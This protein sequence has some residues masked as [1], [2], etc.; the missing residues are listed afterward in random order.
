MNLLVTQSDTN[1]KKGKNKIKINNL[2]DLS[3]L[4]PIQIISL[5]RKQLK[6]S[7]LP[8]SFLNIYF[9]LI[10]D[11][12]SFQYSRSCSMLKIAILYLC[13]DL[14][15]SLIF[16]AL[17]W[18]HHFLNKLVLLQ[19]PPAT[20]KRSNYSIKPIYL[21]GPPTSAEPYGNSTV[22]RPGLPHGFVVNNGLR[23]QHLRGFQ[24]RE[25]TN[26][27]ECKLPGNSGGQIER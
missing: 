2:S 5:F 4:Q 9:L 12:S 13:N 3:D 17:V 15:P 27:C 18:Y 1:S 26:S 14:I 11:P 21:R 16:T 22:P 6:M 20:L 10:S 19:Y 25:L 24:T 23:R 7:T 8:Y